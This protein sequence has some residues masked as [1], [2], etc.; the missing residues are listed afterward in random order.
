ML[1][2]LK[3]REQAHLP[4]GDLSGVDNVLELY[5]Y[6]SEENYKIL[7][8]LLDDLITYGASLKFEWNSSSDKQRVYYHGSSFEFKMWYKNEV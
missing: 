3:C 7:E 2:L 1:V 8:R 4:D 5:S 6:G